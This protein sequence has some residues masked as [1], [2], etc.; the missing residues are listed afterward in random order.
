MT[1]LPLTCG[2]TID[3]WGI[4]DHASRAVLQ[5]EPLPRFNSLVLLGK[6]LI[7]FGKY[8]MPK[9]IRSDNASVFKAM[10]F[11]VALKLLDVN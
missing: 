1:G 7:A 3:A 4:I 11:Q 8:G 5:L 9:A 6:L 2:E 10:P